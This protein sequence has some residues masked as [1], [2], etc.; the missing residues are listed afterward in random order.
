MTANAS[1]AAEIS[2]GCDMSL[3]G[4][5]LPPSASV[6]GRKGRLKLGK[7]SVIS[8]FSFCFRVLK[9]SRAG[10]VHSTAV[11]SFFRRVPLLSVSNLCK[12]AAIPE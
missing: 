7:A 9:G 6:V 2:D 11:L 4:R 5:H 10:S 1:R 12:G 8:S 3:P